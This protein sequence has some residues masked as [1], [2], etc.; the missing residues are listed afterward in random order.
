M[1][2]LSCLGDRKRRTLQ[3]SGQQGQLG[4]APAGC[5]KCHGKGK[6]CSRREPAS[7]VARVH[8]RYMTTLSRSNPASTESRL[9][10]YSLTRC[11]VCE[12]THA[13]TVRYFLA[14]L[15]LRRGTLG[16]RSVIAP[17]APHGRHLTSTLSLMRTDRL[18]S[19]RHVTQHATL[20]ASNLFSS[21]MSRRGT[22]TSWFY[23]PFFFFFYPFRASTKAHQ[24]NEFHE[25]SFSRT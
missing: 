12:D 19:R 10:A 3:L 8:G 6:S 7:F 22:L 4:F 5:S 1:V 25:K 13:S 20:C 11:F 17:H 18:P 24:P 21:A 16:Q 2:L 23:K 9:R 15:T 14:P